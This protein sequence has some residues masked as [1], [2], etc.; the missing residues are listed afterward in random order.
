MPHRIHSFSNPHLK[1]LKRMHRVA[2]DQ[3]EFLVEGTHLVLEALTAHWP[4]ESV[5]FTDVWADKHRQLIQRLPSTITQYEVDSRWLQQAATTD[6]PDGVV[7]IALVPER[8][9]EGFSNDPKE[10]RLTIAADGIQDPGNAGTL[11]R[12]GVATGANRMFLSPDSV[13]PLHPKLLRSTAG[14]WFRSPPQVASME[15][16]IPFAKRLGVRVLA[17]GLRGE[18]IWNLDLRGPTLFIL[19]NEGSGIRTETAQRADAICTIPMAQGVESL[20]V[21]TAGTI[22]LYETMRQRNRP[23]SE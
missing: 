5:F 3:R 4:L 12:M 15:A 17:T 20:N 9:G 23:R 13:S 11:L 10:W 22:L 14:Q 19:G 7:A 6:H 1:R 18:A 16:L 2:A 8:A 21:A